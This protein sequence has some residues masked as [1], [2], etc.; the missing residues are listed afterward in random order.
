MP[1][2]VL[3]PASL[4]FQPRPSYPYSPGAKGGRVVVT[5]GQVAWDEQGN[6][7]G[8]GDVR[9]QTIQTL[10]NVK[11]VLAE[12]GATFDDVLKC[13]V[14]LSDIR[15]FQIMN[16]VFAETFPDKPPARTTVQAALA[17]PEMLVEIEVL[18]YVE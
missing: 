15:H 16:A 11:A 2:E 3:R 5:A 17:E 12:A 6:L 1:R 18:A 13:T 7:V 8:A 14:F 10:K 9:A 4:S